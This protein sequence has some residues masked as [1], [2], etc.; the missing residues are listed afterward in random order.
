MPEAE[1]EAPPLGFDAELEPVGLV[2]ALGLLGF[3]E[4]LELSLAPAPLPS[5]PV[6]LTW[7]PTWS[8]SLEVSPAN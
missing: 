1:E 8:L 7:W 6:I 5:E 3:A 2:P 4:E